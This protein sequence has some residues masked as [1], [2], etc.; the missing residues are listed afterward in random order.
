MTVVI[1]R[2]YSAFL[3]SDVIPAKPHGR[4]TKLSLDGVVHHLRTDYSFFL[5]SL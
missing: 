5:E 3:G 4:Y 2:P 1:I